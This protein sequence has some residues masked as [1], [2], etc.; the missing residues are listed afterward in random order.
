MS[1]ESWEQKYWNHTVNSKNWKQDQQ[2]LQLRLQ[3]LRT[4]TSPSKWRNIRNHSDSREASASQST[5]PRFSDCSL[6]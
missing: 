4:D 1:L 6:T 3:T 5:F 2:C